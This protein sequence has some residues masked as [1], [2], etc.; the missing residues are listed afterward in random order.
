MERVNKAK[1]GATATAP[2]N[3]TVSKAKVSTPALST[4]SSGKSTVAEL[5]KNLAKKK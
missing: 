3:T 5:K 1:K 4:V 2:V